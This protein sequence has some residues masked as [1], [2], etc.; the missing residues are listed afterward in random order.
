MIN[1]NYAHMTDF[2]AQS[3]PQIYSYRRISSLKQ[4]KG[5]GLEMQREDQ[6]LQELS[7]RYQLPISDHR[8]VDNGK[9]AFHGHHIRDGELGWFLGAVNDGK[10]APGSLLVVHAL[11]R[12]SR[13]EIKESTHMLTSVLRAGIGIFSILNDRI[14][15]DPYRED[16]NATDI[17][18]AVTLLESSHN[19]SYTKQ[20]R[21]K[22]LNDRAVAKHLAGERHSSG[23]AYSIQSGGNNV[24]WSDDSDCSVKLH[25]LYAP[26]AR[27]I[28][29]RL[30]N[31]QSPY[32]IVRW[33][34]ESDIKC[35]IKRSDKRAPGAWSIHV[36]RRIHEHRAL[37]GEKVFKGVIL[38]GYYPPLLST[39][40]YYRLLDAR[41]NR[42][43]PKSP[44]RTSAISWFAG[45]AQVKCRHCGAGVHMNTET[46][47]RG[48]KIINYR[49]S[50]HRTE[51]KCPGWSKRAALIE[52]AVVEA[53]I[54]KIWKPIEHILD[55][56]ISTIQQKI[57]EKSS[58]LDKL[59]A[60]ADE[61]D[62]PASYRKKI[63]TLEKEVSD[64]QDELE[65][66][67]V[68]EAAERAKDTASLPERWR[69]IADEALDPSN[70][71][72]RLHMREL[73]RDSVKE[74]NIGR[75]SAVD[76]DRFTLVIVI[77]FIDNSGITITLGRNSTL[78]ILDT[79]TQLVTPEVAHW[80][81]ETPTNG[82][83]SYRAPYAE[84]KEAQVW[85]EGIKEELTNNDSDAR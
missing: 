60:Q 7:E 59:N 35:P 37:I 1:R 65:Y 85:L 28:C 18:I 63:S 46:V 54:P 26:I 14:F 80:L 29:L 64:L 27:E 9:S 84:L 61:E 70:D 32:R 74:M 10:V 82:L 49:C 13:Q 40:E 4:A 31:G 36:I 66:A 75:S 67:K 19:E 39:D 50:N 58:K 43:R 44:G 21:T 15:C 52:K 11:D 3:K 12:F 56:R 8:M 38:E 81:S 73:I 34:N 24:W 51:T 16:S 41:S 6:K 83:N 69:Q 2:T 53:I 57:V 5:Q 72:A 30:I 77:K 17:L 47:A 68:E 76:Y 55:S 48:G 22:R 33:L 42:K 45:V 62:F 71:D 79:G 20:A 25:E 78:S 23:Y